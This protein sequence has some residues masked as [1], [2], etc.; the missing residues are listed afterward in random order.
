MPGSRKLTPLSLSTQSAWADGMAEIALPR[1]SD[2]HA[3]RTNKEI[4][5]RIKSFI[6]VCELI[7]VRLSFAFFAQARVIVRC[8]RG[9]Q[10]LLNLVR[11]HALC[12]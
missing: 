12:L 10:V 7:S 3:D 6:G 9:F 4:I 8:S 1:R 11:M 5:A 2:S